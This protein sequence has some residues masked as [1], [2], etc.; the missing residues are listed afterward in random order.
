MILTPK[1]VL[2]CSHL[3]I[4]CVNER[5]SKQILIQNFMLNDFWVIFL[6]LHDCIHTQLVLYQG[7]VSFLLRK[8]KRF[9]LNPRAVY[10][11]LQTSLQQH[12][13]AVSFNLFS[14][15]ATMN[16]VQSIPINLNS[17]MRTKC[18]THRFK[19]YSISYDIHIFHAQG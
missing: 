18:H 9:G 1:P 7:C 19:F 15:F 12:K 8:F 3:F 6:A 5:V 2:R 13:T 14:I 16:S 10:T 11:A 17:K 4:E